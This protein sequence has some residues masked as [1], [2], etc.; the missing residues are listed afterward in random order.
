MSV[1]IKGVQFVTDTQGNK[2]AVQLDLSQ[3]GELWED[4]YDGMFSERARFGAKRILGVSQ[5]AVAGRRQT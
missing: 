2:I 5:R 1:E 3:W 4:I